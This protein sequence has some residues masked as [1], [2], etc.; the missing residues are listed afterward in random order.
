MLT[1]AWE[2]LTSFDWEFLVSILYPWKDKWLRIVNK[3]LLLPEP[4]SIVSN[5]IDGSSIIFW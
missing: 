2:K 3:D 4:M 1:S 5:L